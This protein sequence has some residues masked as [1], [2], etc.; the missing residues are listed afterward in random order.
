MNNEKVIA[1][2]FSAIMG[3]LG[4]DLTDDS[5]RDTPKRVAKMFARELFYGLDKQ[6]FPKITVQE[7]KFGY[8]QMLVESN[9][10]V[11]SICEHHFVPILGVCHLAY[12][13]G[14]KIIGLSKF[15]RIVDYYSRRPQ[16]QEKLTN[17]IINCLKAHLD[18]S[19]VAVVIDAMHMCVKLR[20]VEHDKTITRT[21]ALSGKFMDGIVRAEFFNGIPKPSCISQVI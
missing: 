19:D 15:N 16:V 7:N 4:L 8:D 20:G 12:I 3:E 5:L 10:T 2:H 9:I 14:K 11:K 1:K 6:N 17:D 18:T 13:P 21:S